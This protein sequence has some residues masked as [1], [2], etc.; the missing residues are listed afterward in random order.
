MGKKS[1]IR[2]WLVLCLIIQCIVFSYWYNCVRILLR[3]LRR[4]FS[5]FGKKMYGWQLDGWL[6]FKDLRFFNLIM[7]VKQCWR[8]IKAINSLFSQVFKKK[9]FHLSSFFGAKLGASPFLCLMR[10]LRGLG[11]YVGGTML[12]D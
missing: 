6:E 8:V 5:S 7:L 12:G 4:S 1:F 11:Y 2:L 10:I 3:I 9:V